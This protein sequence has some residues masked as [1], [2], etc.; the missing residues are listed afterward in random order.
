MKNN[1]LNL[2]KLIVGE[3]ATNCY[4]ISQ[5]K[6]ALIVDPGDDYN[7]IANY[8]KKQQFSPLAI[9]LTHGHFDH[10]LAAQ[11]LQ[12]AYQLPIYANLLDTKLVESV[13]KHYQFFMSKKRDC[14]IPKITNDLNKQNKLVSKQLQCRARELA[15]KNFSCE[16]IQT[17]GHT[18][19]SI[20][21]YFQKQAWLFSGD[22]LFANGCL[23]RTDFAESVPKKMNSSVKK[24][25]NLPNETII[26]PGHGKESKI[27]VEKNTLIGL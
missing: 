17:P 26:Y 7:K 20:C 10:I 2:K 24:L 16:I 15:I 23:G 19:G 11:Q 4:I 13:A 8:L 12:K 5:N 25:L 22:T 27:G 1:N 9:L 14:Q 6:Q 18:Q 3:L 21:F